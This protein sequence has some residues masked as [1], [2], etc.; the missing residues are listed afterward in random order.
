MF[1]IFILELFTFLVKF[2]INGRIAE[3]LHDSKIFYG[4]STF[5]SAQK[6]YPPKSV[7]V[8]RDYF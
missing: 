7:N 1:E 2:Y 8:R 5:R 4:F 3:T 6:L